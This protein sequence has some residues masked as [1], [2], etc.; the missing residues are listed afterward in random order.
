[1]YKL[2]P[3]ARVTDLLDAAGGPA[4]DADLDQ[5]NLAAPVA[6]PGP[7]VVRV[8]V[9]PAWSWSTWPAPSCRRASIA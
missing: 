2:P 1:V 4:A 8:S 6:V 9:R 3:G 7:T 5:L